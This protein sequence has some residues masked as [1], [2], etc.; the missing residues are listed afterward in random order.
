MTLSVTLVIGSL[1]LDT[2]ERFEPG[3]LPR[4]VRVIRRVDHL[5]DILIGSRRFLGDSTERW[6]ANQ[7]SASG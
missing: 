2:H 6:T 7:N 4:Q 5:A 3:D 1:P